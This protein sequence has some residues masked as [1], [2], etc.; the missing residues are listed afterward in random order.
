[1]TTRLENCE[2]ALKSMGVVNSSCPRGVRKD[3]Q[4]I[5]DHRER[6]TREVALSIVETRNEAEF[7]AGGSFTTIRARE[8]CSSLRAEAAEEGGYA[9]R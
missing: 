6:S 8:A 1:M 9:Q 3:E 5:Y 4:Q 2:S 7:V